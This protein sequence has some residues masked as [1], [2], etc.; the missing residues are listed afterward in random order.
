M[1]IP[2]MTRFLSR[3]REPS[4]WGG[5]A[6]LLALTGLSQEQSQAVTDLLAAAAATASIFLPEQGSPR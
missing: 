1:E 2:T 6:V 5:V 3:F 4:T